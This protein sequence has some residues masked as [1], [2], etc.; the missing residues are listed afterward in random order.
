MK[1]LTTLPRATQLRKVEALLEEEPEELEISSTSS[2]ASRAEACR[3]DSDSWHNSSIASIDSSFRRSP[4]IWFSKFYGWTKIGENWNSAK[5]SIGV[6]SESER[7]E[8][9]RSLSLSLRKYYAFVFLG[10][11][12]WIE[13]QR[14]EMGKKGREVMRE[15]NPSLSLSLSLSLFLSTLNFLSLIWIFFFLVYNLVAF[16]SNFKISLSLFLTVLF[17]V[18]LIFFNFF[19]FLDWIWIGLWDLFRH[20]D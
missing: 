3:I 13:F 2:S 9:I 12:L 7:S 16:F 15:K 4:T 10:F 11:V 14:F 20:S 1:E 18:S 6:K 8:G 17:C 5:R 19:F